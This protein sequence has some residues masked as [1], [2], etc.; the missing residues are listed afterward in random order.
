MLVLTGDES[1]LIKRV[2][3]AL[4]QGTGPIL[5]HKVKRAK[6]APSLQQQQKQGKDEAK[7]NE[8]VVATWGEPSKARGVQKMA[9]GWLPSGDGENERVVLAARADG[10]VDFMSREDG[11]VLRTL[12]L[13]DDMFTQS[14][15]MVAPRSTAPAAQ[16]AP[17]FIGL[18][19]A[20]STGRVLTCTSTG[21]LRCTSLDD[22]QPS[23]LWN[24]G[25]DLSCMKVCE[26]IPNIFA[27][28]GKE[29]ELCLWDIN[30][31][32]PIAAIN[33][34]ASALENATKTDMASNGK[35]SKKSKKDRRAAHAAA[36]SF[37]QPLPGSA[38]SSPSKPYY[39]AKNVPNDHLDLRVPVWVTDIDFASDSD[40]TKVLISTGYGG[41]R[42]Y[43][44]KDQSNRP[45]LDIDNV[46]A[47]PI[48]NICRSANNG[49]LVYCADT[50]G[51]VA[52]VDI[53]MGTAANKRI[54]GQLKGYSGAATA[55]TTHPSDSS[56]LATVAADRFLRIHKIWDDMGTTSGSGKKRKGSD[57]SH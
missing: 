50:E 37:C 3:V 18:H 13:V 4:D 8:P 6:P 9:W 10:T 34:D 53:R 44:T 21:I 39:L 51:H 22:E 26:K 52:I 56:L 41:V 2:S 28:G 48:S 35:H 31:A 38:L 47:K 14:N 16:K 23:A 11:S 25:D 5:G 17:R 40:P 45:V 46:S 19:S 29:R 27:V 42:L 32:S 33:G 36:M 43:D 20:S 12:S 15:D 24:L 57:K 49:D 55:M 30:A 1:G 7:A 54:V